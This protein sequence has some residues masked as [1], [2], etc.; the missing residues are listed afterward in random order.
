MELPF[1][2]RMA[3]LEAVKRYNSRQLY[4][5]NMLQTPM[6]PTSRKGQM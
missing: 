4:L 1:V 5:P 6:R 3:E 2:G